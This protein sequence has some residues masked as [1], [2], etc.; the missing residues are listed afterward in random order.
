VGTGLWPVVQTQ[1]RDHDAGQ[2]RRNAERAFAL[3]MLYGR[4][5]R[6]VG[7]ADQR[8]LGAEEVG[9]LRRGA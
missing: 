5:C 6:R 9:Q 8:E 2:R 4:A 1:D 3:P 7:A